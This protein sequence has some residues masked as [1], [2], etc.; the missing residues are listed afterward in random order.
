MG[1]GGGVGRGDGG[2]VSAFEE[3]GRANLELLW[4]VTELFNPDVAELLAQAQVGWWAVVAT[5]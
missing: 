4:R 2:G 1:P 5:R 3:A